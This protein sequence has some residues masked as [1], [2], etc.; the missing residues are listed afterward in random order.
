MAC[1][2]RV[3]IL[4]DRAAWERAL[5]E[6]ASAANGR[7]RQRL[8]AWPLPGLASFLAQACSA[9]EGRWQWNAEGLPNAGVDRSAV[10]VAWWTDFVGRKHARIVGWRGRLDTW[11]LENLF[12]PTGGDRP[13]LALVYPARVLLAHHSGERTLVAVCACGAVGRP[14][15]LG[16]MGTC[17]GLCHDRRQEGQA[18]PRAWAD[19]PP[20]SLGGT[21]VSVGF[22]AASVACS[23]HAQMVAVWTAAG[24]VQVWDVPHGRQLAT[25][26]AGRIRF[27]NLTCVTFDADGRL[28]TGDGHGLVAWWDPDTGA[29]ELVDRGTG[30]VNAIHRTADGSLLAVA[31]MGQKLA[32]LNAAGR[33]PGAEPPAGGYMD[34][35]AFSPDGRT[36]AYAPWTNGVWFCDLATGAH[37]CVI[38]RLQMLVGNLFAEVRSLF[39]SP[40]GKLLAVP[41]WPG[42][43]DE[44]PFAGSV[45]VWDVQRQQIALSLQEQAPRTLC[46]AFSPDS[47]FLITGDGD[48]RVHVWDI[49]RGVRLLALEW[50]H[51]EVCSV[52][53]SADGGLLAS[54]DSAGTVQWWPW[55]AVQALALG[56][57]ETGAHHAGL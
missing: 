7:A 32:V 26:P 42:S 30:R 9:A 50:H 10:A 2:D 36:L 18:P 11:R 35:A 40:D 38:E 51:L 39:F 21:R 45:L 25:L 37:R 19:P 41:W 29:S 33:V 46:A 22:G 20:T 1:H 6:A 27:G 31:R 16:W 12:C 14:E 28:L 4:P 23:P 34:A 57:R 48:C 54:C 17:C 3:L 24:K 44:D 56:E 55:E 5:R 49:A 15:D 53:L 8:L 47:K 52:A 13:A 43:L